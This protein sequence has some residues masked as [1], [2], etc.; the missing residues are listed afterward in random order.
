MKRNDMEAQPC[1]SW[2][3]KL[4]ALHPD[5]L[6][7]E[8]QT[9]LDKHLSSCN[10]CAQTYQDY[11]HLAALVRDLPSSKPVPAL[12]GVSELLVQQD[13]MVFEKLPTEQPGTT[14]SLPKPERL[15]RQRW[16]VSTIGVAA[17]IVMVLIA[18]TLLGNMLLAQRSVPPVA[19][20]GQAPVHAITPVSQSQGPVYTITPQ[21]GPV[22][23]PEASAGGPAIAL[24]PTPPFFLD[25]NLYRNTTVYRVD[26]GAPIQHY[27]KELD[28][29]MVFDPSIVDGV[30]YMTVRL[31]DQGDK[32]SMYALRVS[33]GTVLWKVNPCGDGV[34][35]SPPTVVNG[36]VYLI[37]E[38]N[39]NMSRLYALKADT[40]VPLWYNT[41]S[42]SPAYSILVNQQTLY[43]QQDNQLIAKNTQTGAT[44]WQKSFGVNNVINQAFLVDGIIYIDEGDTFYAVKAS[45]GARIW[46]YHFLDENYIRWVFVDQN[47]VYLYTEQ[48]TISASIYGL[49][50]ATGRQFW[51]VQLDVNVSG[52]T[53]VVD[54]GNLFMSVDV[55][56]KPVHRY[57]TPVKREVVAI[58]GQD[59]R[60]LWW[61]DIPWNKGKL[62]YALLLPPML[63]AGDGRVYLADWQPTSTLGSS[64]AIMGAFRESDGALLWTQ[65]V[66]SQ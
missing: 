13:V 45:D 8:E 7:S 36:A 40:G 46:E 50:R 35:M 19:S 2:S 16:R 62:I 3:E 55:F 23:T 54:H 29:V 30:L 31:M 63:T 6:T 27:L 5:D 4:A 12:P 48:S 53:F 41:F 51:Q 37:C 28:N 61:Q 32:I 66:T 11:H 24:P 15:T 34:N 17:A 20:Q 44:L 59:G 42:G 58:R 60:V 9:Q 33:D 14:L 57:D 43:V 56:A 10:D 39:T 65:D 25:G 22:P 64:K 21:G 26:T 47:V 1:A 52:R 18:G 49:D 38:T